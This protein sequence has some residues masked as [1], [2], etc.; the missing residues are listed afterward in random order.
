[1]EFNSFILVLLVCPPNAP[2]KPKAEL[3]QLQEGHMESDL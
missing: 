3:D 1:M 2:E